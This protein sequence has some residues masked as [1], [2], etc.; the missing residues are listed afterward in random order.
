MR[1][2]G[3]LEQATYI[4]LASANF[5]MVRLPRYESFCSHTILHKGG[6]V[7]SIPNMEADWRFANSPHSRLAGMKAYAGTQLRVALSA[8]QEVAIGSLCVTA[9]TPQGS[10]A[11]SAVV[12]RKLS[13]EPLTKAQELTLIQFAE[14]VVEALENRMR[15]IRSQLR[16]TLLAAID[17]ITPSAT[18]D[19]VHDLV[20]DLARTHYPDC[21][22]GIRC[23]TRGHIQLQRSC[24]ADCP[25]Y[26]NFS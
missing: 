24:V 4:S 20:L 21:Q 10:S 23:L 8:D 6:T 19:N 11:A 5:P 26:L 15:Q 9:N 16:V 25:F 14:I 18:I 3:L 13:T 1:S 17:E 22:I 12:R 7:F 2:K